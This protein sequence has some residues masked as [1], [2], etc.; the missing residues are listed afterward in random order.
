MTDFYWAV[1]CNPSDLVY[2]RQGIG[3]AGVQRILK[4]TLQLHGEQAKEAEGGEH[5]GAGEEHHPSD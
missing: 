2:F 1:S 5:D 4:V 3:E